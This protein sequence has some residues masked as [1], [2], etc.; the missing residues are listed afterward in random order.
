MKLLR[1][2]QHLFNLL[3]ERID[4]MTAF[5]RIDALEASI[6]ALKAQIAALPAATDPAPAIAAVDAKADAIRADLGVPTPPAA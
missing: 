5:E 2:L 1:Y 4:Y 3:I 6:T